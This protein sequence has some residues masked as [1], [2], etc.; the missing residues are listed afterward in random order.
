MIK[1]SSSKRRDE[2]MAYALILPFLSM[3]IIFKLYPMVYGLV[4]SFLGRNSI[5]TYSDTTFRGFENY[6]N[7]LQNPEFW[8]SLGRSFIFSLVYT[9]FVMVVGFFLAL[10]L[11]RKFRTRTVVRTMFYLPYVTNIIAVG[12]V[13]KFLFNPT[14]GPINALLKVFGITGMKWLTSPDMALPLTALIAGYLAVAFNV[15]TVLAALQDVPS[16]LYEVA[17]IEGTSAWQN[18]VYVTLPCIKPALWM[19]LTITI[20]NSFKNYTVIQALTEGGPGNT[21]TVLS[22]QIYNDAFIYSKYSYAAA[23]G[24][25]MTIFIVLVNQAMSAVRRIWDK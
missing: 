12:I 22:M 16:D 1:G 20:I 23:E 9:V 5:R 15:I 21:T 7:V 8:A 17:K 24:V 13:F 14:K 2:K 25:F 4:V 11:N 19:L 6:L 3:F 10:M 18:L